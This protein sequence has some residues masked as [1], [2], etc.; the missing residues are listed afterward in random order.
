MSSLP[1]GEH[2][3]LSDR[4]SAAL[5]TSAGS[6][7]WLCMPRFDS[8]SIFARILDDEAGHWSIRPDTE[9]Q[10]ERQY[11]DGSMV[12]LTTFHTSTGTLELRD[13][14]VLGDTRDPHSLGEHAP[15]LLARTATCTRGSIE[16][17][18]SFRVRSEYGLV[19]PVTTTVH[20]GLL[21]SGG[22]NQLTLSSTV[23]LQ[24]KPD[25]ASMLTA[26]RAIEWLP[27]GSRVD[28]IAPGYFASDMTKTV[29][30]QNP[31]WWPSG[32][33]GSQP[34]GGSTR[35]ARAAGDLPV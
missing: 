21:A 17:I 2:A 30:A 25:E 9:F 4:H 7:D 32:C 22:A 27:L 23:P 12:L 5:V 35:G 11:V 26:S 10:T 16:V 28:A 13:A 1:I 19:A 3:L 29:T 24:V 6:V 31:R 15:H 33:A 18:M 20:G 14:L 34:G 8:P